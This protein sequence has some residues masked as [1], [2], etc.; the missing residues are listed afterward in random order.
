MIKIV[1]RIVK[2][3]KIG[4]FSSVSSTWDHYDIGVKYSNNISQDSHPKIDDTAREGL[5]QSYIW[6]YYH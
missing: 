4:Q 5:Y 3:K 1:Q 2:L 6:L